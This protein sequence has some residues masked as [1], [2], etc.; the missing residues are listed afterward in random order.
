M[1]ALRLAFRDSSPRRESTVLSRTSSRET[2]RLPDCN[3]MARLRTRSKVKSG[4]SIK[5]DP[6]TMGRLTT[7][8]IMSSSSRIW[9]M[10]LVRSPDM[11]VVRSRKIRVPSPSKTK[12]TMGSPV[13]GCV[14]AKAWTRLSPVR[15][16]PLLPTASLSVNSEQSAFRQVRSLNTNWAVWPIRPLASSTPPL[17]SKDSMGRILFARSSRSCSCSTVVRVGVRT[18]K[19]LP[20]PW[21]TS[22]LAKSRSLS[23]VLRSATAIPCW[24]ATCILSV[25][26]SKLKLPRRPNLSS[27]PLRIFSRDS[28]ERPAISMLKRLDTTTCRGRSTMASSK[29]RSLRVLSR[30][31]WDTLPLNA[32]SILVSSTPGSCI[33]TRSS[34]NLWTV[35]SVIPKALIRLSMVSTTPS[36]LS[37]VGLFLWN[38]KLL[39]APNCSTNSSSMVRS[40]SSSREG[41]SIA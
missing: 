22:A 1:A 36:M 14:P 27:R 35:G 38:R 37:S 21:L 40:R 3:C 25:A 16:S 20:V 10:H 17:A 32:R 19:E 23:V 24:K 34:P 18:L 33:R 2:G 39:T 5:P 12:F 11:R 7:G 41:R 4:P 29:P 9:A 26:S 31:P 28:W 8:Q 30:V 13:V 15:D 6:L